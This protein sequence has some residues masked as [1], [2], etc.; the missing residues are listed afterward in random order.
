MICKGELS[1][2]R[3][4][5]MLSISRDSDIL[6]VQIC[7]QLLLLYFSI[8]RLSQIWLMGAPLSQL[9]F[10]VLLTW[11]HW[12]LGTFL[13]SVMRRC[14]RPTL[15]VSCSRP[16]DFC[17][18]RKAWLISVRTCIYKP[19]LGIRCVH[20]QRDVTASGPRVPL[21]GPLLM[22]FTGPVH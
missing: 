17:F 1:L 8:F 10:H 15:Y 12:F 11:P 18:C 9:P 21:E 14:S 6:K 16:P 13:V 3:I 7:Y 22:K 2:L 20:Y 4:V 19:D 5:F